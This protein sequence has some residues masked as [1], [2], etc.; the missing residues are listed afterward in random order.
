MFRNVSFQY[1]DAP[2]FDNMNLVI[3]PGSC[4]G[5]VG[6][7]GSGK[8]SL[9]H[10]LTRQYEISSGAIS[11]DGIDISTVSK[12]SLRRHVAVVPQDAPLFNRT[13]FDNI[14]YG[15]PSASPGEV[16]A[17]A[18][19][20]QCH[21]MI[22]TLSSGYDTIVGEKGCKLSSGQRQRIY[23][24]RAF[25]KDAPILILDESTSALD[26]LT[27][28]SLQKRVA[29]R[30]R[31]KTVI[32]IAHKLSSMRWLDRILVMQ[33]GRV[34]EDGCHDKLIDCSGQYALMWQAYLDALAI[35]SV[36]RL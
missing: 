15:N 11:I 22:E 35:D 20:A 27:E 8:T 16:F 1:A 7:S 2:L 28:R 5:M 26:V 17:A 23:I 6:C 21:D 3:S 30:I 31:N 19:D 32:V 14:H 33:N 9:I 4:V 34:V 18:R 29:A 12:E 13:I 10:L 36:V 24:A 25:L